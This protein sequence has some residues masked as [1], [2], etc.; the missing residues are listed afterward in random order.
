MTTETLQ[1]RI[2]DH[3]DFTEQVPA[4]VEGQRWEQIRW[5]THDAGALGFRAI[6]GNQV[7][8]LCPECR[9]SLVAWW[10]AGK[11]PITRLPFS[12]G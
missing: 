7:A 1:R 9:E 10:R 5:V 12:S 6:K 11:W 4:T 3:C 8:D 2:C